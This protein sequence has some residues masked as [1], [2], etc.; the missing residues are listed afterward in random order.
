RRYGVVAGTG[1][2]LEELARF[3]FSDEDLRFLQDRK[4]V[5]K[6]TIKWLENYHFSGKIRGYREGE[7][8]FPDSPI[9]QVEGTFGECT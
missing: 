8:F 5:S 6:D 3:H 9:L 4:I 1:R 7:M 2:I